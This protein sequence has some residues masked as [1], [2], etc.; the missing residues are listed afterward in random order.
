MGRFLQQCSFVMLLLQLAQGAPDGAC[1]EHSMSHASMAGGCVTDRSQRGACAAAPAA[2]A[3]SVE[4]RQSSL[5]VT[6]LR[7]WLR[8][9]QCPACAGVPS[10]EEG[11]ARLAVALYRG[12]LRALPATAASWFGSLRDRALAGQI[13][14]CCARSPWRMIS[15][16]SSWC[17]CL[18]M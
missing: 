8:V 9:A 17:I 16:D 10:T 13:E 3:W 11:W 18:I 1:I 5:C 7:W 4:G 2:S 6:A 14:V 12:V 15:L